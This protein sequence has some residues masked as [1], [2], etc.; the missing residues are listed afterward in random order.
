[1]VTVPGFVPKSPPDWS[2][3]YFGLLYC[4]KFKVIFINDIVPV[5]KRPRLMTWFII[6]TLSGTPAQTI[7]QTA[8]RRK[9]WMIFIP[10]PA[11][12]QA[13]F[14]SLWNLLNL[15]FPKLQKMY[16]RVFFAAQNSTSYHKFYSSSSDYQS[17]I[18]VEQNSLQIEFQ[19]L[20]KLLKKSLKIVNRYL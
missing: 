17:S 19:M 9:S 14:H 10:T 7:F 6:A 12:L 18:N 2:W 20:G 3:R 13:F 15:S 16:F 5:K 4:S 8:V 1:L 11:S